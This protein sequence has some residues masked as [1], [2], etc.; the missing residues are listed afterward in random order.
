MNTR[1]SGVAAIALMLAATAASATEQSPVRL[2]VANVDGGGFVDEKTDSAKDLAKTFRHADDPKATKDRIVLVDTADA[3]DIVVEIIERGDVETGTRRR[4][5]IAG[6]TDA[7]K[8]HRITAKL[9]AGEYTATLE[10]ESLAPLHTWGSAAIAI[11]TKLEK[12][13]KDNGAKI[14]EG[15][16][17]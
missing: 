11:R 2:Y 7:E 1:R 16:R 13:V 5:W 8:G 3:A 17:Q 4:S 12:F 14:I 10:G 15:R 6:Q 9:T